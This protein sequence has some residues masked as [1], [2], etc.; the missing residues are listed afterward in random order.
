[1]A[2][3]GTLGFKAPPYDPAAAVSTY[4][5]ALSTKAV[6]AGIDVVVSALGYDV[7]Q[8]QAT[9]VQAAKAA[10]VKRFVPSEWGGD[11]PRYLRHDP[12]PKKE[13]V[14]RFLLPA[15]EA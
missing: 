1:M 11:T 14:S 7:L 10:G 15:E 12:C 2:L 13:H 3:W 6:L 5:K 8:Q 4:T 9:L